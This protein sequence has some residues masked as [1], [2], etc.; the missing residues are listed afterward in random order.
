LQDVVTKPSAAERIGDE[1]NAAYVGEMNAVHSLLEL[2]LRLIHDL[3]VKIAREQQRRGA[4][5]AESH[6]QMNRFLIAR[7]DC[8]PADRQQSRV[9]SLSR[10]M[11]RMDAELREIAALVSTRHSE[12]FAKETEVERIREQVGLVQRKGM[13]LTTAL[14]PQFN[15]ALQKEI[16]DNRDALTEVQKRLG[17]FERKLTKLGDDEAL[18]KRKLRQFREI[19]LDIQREGL[20]IQAQGISA[21]QRQLELRQKTAEDEFQERRMVEQLAALQ[22]EIAQRNTEFDEMSMVRDIPDLLPPSLP[23]RPRRSKR[24]LKRKLAR[25]LE[26]FAMI[27]TQREKQ[28]YLQQEIRSVQAKLHLEQYHF[29]KL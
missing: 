6:R 15:F 29:E 11:R 22:R 1:L 16:A 5:R 3:H 8:I 23:D 18:L 2:H 7:V 4:Q 26:I 13:D 19:E 24:E 20:N 25:A 12:L 9:D 21:E 28:D 10:R 27:R 17:R 14:N